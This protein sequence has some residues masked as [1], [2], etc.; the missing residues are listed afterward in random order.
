M[1]LKASKIIVLLE[2]GQHIVQTVFSLDAE[3]NAT[4]LS[5]QSHFK[6]VNGIIYRSS[7]TGLE[8][9]PLLFSKRTF[10]FS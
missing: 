2:T 8:P 4:E 10:S 6:E 5:V 3:K 7:A 9:P 1:L